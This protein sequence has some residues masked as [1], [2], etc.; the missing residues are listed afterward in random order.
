MSAVGVIG[1][2]RL[3]SALVECL[4]RGGFDVIGC[5]THPDRI[6]WLTTAGADSACAFELALRCRR[7]LVCLP[8]YEIILGLFPVFRPATILI[9]TGN[10]T[11]EE[12]EVAAQ[13]L[14]TRGIAYIDAPVCDWWEQVRERGGRV[15]CGGDA[16]AVAACRD[17][18]ETFANPFVFAGSAGA[19]NRMKLDFES[20][21]H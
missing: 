9:N 14:R 21:G 1:V 4:I 6:R 7:I 19:G 2:G 16:S 5:D 20:K 11:P 15:F 12:S 13:E 10:C 3:G 18:F 17:I 8:A